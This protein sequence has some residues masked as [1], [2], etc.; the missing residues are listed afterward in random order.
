MTLSE[1]IQKNEELLAQCKVKKD[2]LERQ[3]AILEKKI[4]NQRHAL[5]NQR[6]IRKETDEGSETS[7]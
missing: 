2:N 5:L 7:D 4:L 6:E 3:I 1:K